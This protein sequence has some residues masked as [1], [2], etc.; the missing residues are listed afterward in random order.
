[1]LFV[2]RLILLACA[3]SGEPFHANGSCDVEVLR[4]KYRMESY[5]FV[6]QLGGLLLQRVFYFVPQ[7]EFRLRTHEYL[8]EILVSSLKTLVY[9]QIFVSVIIRRMKFRFD[10]QEATND[11]HVERHRVSRSKLL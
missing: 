10:R 6:R 4:G 7:I 9:Y 5:L 2:L 1:M 3:E 8:E 11:S